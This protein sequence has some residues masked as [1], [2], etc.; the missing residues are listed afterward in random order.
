MQNMFLAA[1][2]LTAYVPQSGGAMVYAEERIVGLPAW[3]TSDED[4]YDIETSME[5]VATLVLNGAVD[6]RSIQ[7]R[8]GLT[9][10][11]DITI[12]KPAAPPEPQEPFLAPDSG[13]SASSL[14]EL[15][16]LKLELG[17]GEVETLVIDR[18]ERPSEN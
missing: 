9:G 5:Q 6:G 7:D 11:Y 12:L 8:T 14:A 13:P 10:K 2:I 15:L 1:P 16:G 3:L 17:K 4:H 18:V